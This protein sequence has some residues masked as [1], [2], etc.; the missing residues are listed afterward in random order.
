MLQEDIW[1]DLCHGC[2]EPSTRRESKRLPMVQS[3]DLQAPQPGRLH[4][5]IRWRRDIIQLNPRSKDVIRMSFWPCIAIVIVL[6]FHPLPQFP[7]AWFWLT[8]W[9]LHIVILLNTPA[10]MFWLS[11]PTSIP[12]FHGVRRLFFPNAFKHYM[13]EIKYSGVEEWAWKITKRYWKLPEDTR[14][15]VMVVSKTFLALNMILVIWFTFFYP[16]RS[17]TDLF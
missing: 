16:L 10:L 9:I 17:R 8:M 12:I 14:K 6:G 5:A 13:G 4:R 11:L 15:M 7:P 3:H 1:S 2:V